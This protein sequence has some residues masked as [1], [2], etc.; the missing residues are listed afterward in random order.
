MGTNSIREK[1]I[2]FIQDEVET[3]SSIKYV[4]RKQPSYND[5]KNFS[6]VQL[7]AVAVIG[8]LPTPTEKPVGRRVAGIDMIV[9]DLTVR[10][11]TYFQARV[12]PDV[13]VSIL[14][15]DLWAKLYQDTTKGGLVISTVLKPQQDYEYWE[16]YGAFRI[17]VQTQYAHSI[18]G[19]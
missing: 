7:P 8:G 11:F 14:L 1:I 13:M 16:P 19:I 5:L 2:N 12:D 15:D 3:V 10:L 6:N 18:G 17:N 9:S 4:V